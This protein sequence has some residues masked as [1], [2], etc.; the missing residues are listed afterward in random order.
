MPAGSC[1]MAA[2]KEYCGAANHGL[3]EVEHVMRVAN[4]GTSTITSF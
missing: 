3:T 4:V 1:D 2:L